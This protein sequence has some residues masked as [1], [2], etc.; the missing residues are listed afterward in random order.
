MIIKLPFL[1][2]LAKTD[3]QG[4]TAKKREFDG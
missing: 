1:G 4:E 2:Y 3:I